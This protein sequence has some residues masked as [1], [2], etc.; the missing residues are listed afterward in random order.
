MA[1]VDVERREGSKERRARGEG[2]LRRMGNDRASSELCGGRLGTSSRRPRAPARKIPPPPLNASAPVA[3]T[4]PQRIGTHWLACFP[5]F[6]RPPSGLHFARRAALS[7][8]FSL[9]PSSVSPLLA[10][11]FSVASLF[12]SPSPPSPRFPAFAL[13]LLLPSP[14]PLRDFSARGRARPA[15]RALARVILPPDENGDAGDVESTRGGGSARAQQ[16]AAKR[17]ARV[18]GPTNESLAAEGKATKNSVTRG[19]GPRPLRRRRRTCAQRPVGVSPVSASLLP[20]PPSFLLR[21][22]ARY[23]ASCPGGDADLPAAPRRRPGGTA[24][25][26]RGRQARLADSATSACRPGGKAART[27]GRG[28]GRSCGRGQSPQRVGGR[29][30]D[31]GGGARLW[32]ARSTWR[33]RSG[34]RGGGAIGGD[35]LGA[36]R[37]NAGPKGSCVRR[38]AR[39]EKPRTAA[40]GEGRG[41]AARPTAGRGRGG[42]RE[43]RGEWAPGAAGAINA[44]RD[45]DAAR[46]KEGVH[47]RDGGASPM[48]S[49]GEAPCSAGG[50]A[51]PGGERKGVEG[52][53]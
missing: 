30:A 32:D 26:C 45:G 31:E 53:R 14:L 28:A 50:A 23:T 9:P 22:R 35:E 52:G 51:K 46:S 15:R 38:G 39:E 34:G 27:R 21:R 49:T 25:G 29:A 4:F 10:L 2:A 36:C 17:N 48:R 24:R 8:F 16:R 20:L 3:W 6:L 47:N 19:L 37:Q 42:E 40:V 43:G 1:D 33:V 12:S 7:L 13:T 5:T 44:G 18:R 11:P 41:G